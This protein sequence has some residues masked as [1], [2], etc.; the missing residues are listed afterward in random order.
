MLLYAKTYENTKT[1]N[2]NFPIEDAFYAED[3]LAVVADGIT[4]DP[5]GIADFKEASFQKFLDCYP[6]PSGAE[7]AAKEICNTFKNDRM[8]SLVETM[9]KAN[10]N[11]RILNEKYVPFCDYLENDYYG[12]VCSC[13]FISNNILNW[14]YVCDCGILVY[15]KEGNIK[16]QTEDDKLLVDPYIDSSGMLWNLPSGRMTVRKKYRNCPGFYID[17][18]L[19]S[20]GS[21]TGELQANEFIKS[22]SISLEK[23]DIIIVYSDGFTEYFKQNDFYRCLMNIKE[24]KLLFDEYVE[25]IA[26]SD[27]EKYGKEK[28][29]V[30]LEAYF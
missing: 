13:V 4:R 5:I 6:R 14:S 24:N 2:Q 22:G 23:G 16:F 30:V 25:K 15:D 10:E 28:T 12:A 27:Y 1:I 18:N 26:L 20:Y 3:N 17:G 11:V 8:E 7:L 9:K 21:F 29:I 19:A